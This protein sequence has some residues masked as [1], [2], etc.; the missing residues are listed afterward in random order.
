M[1]SPVN[2]DYDLAVV[3]VAHSNLKMDGW[4]GGP[5]FT[6]NAHPKFPDWIPLLSVR[7]EK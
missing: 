1:S 4:K 7:P 6:V 3:L 5:I 2:G